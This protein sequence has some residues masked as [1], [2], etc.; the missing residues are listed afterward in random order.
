MAALQADLK[1]HV[2][3]CDGRWRVIWKLAAVLGGMVAIT[4]AIILM[5]V[6]S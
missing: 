1:G 6:R 2:V 4:E 3:L 5:Q